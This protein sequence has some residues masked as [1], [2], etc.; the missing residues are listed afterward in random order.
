MSHR[1]HF[2]IQKNNNIGW[3]E[4]GEDRLKPNED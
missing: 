4:A 3:A 1:R 2:N